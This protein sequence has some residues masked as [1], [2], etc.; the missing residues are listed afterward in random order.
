MHEMALHA[1]PVGQLQPPI[2]TDT[3]RDGLL[4]AEPLSAG[5][6]S[7]LS[8]C[9]TAIEGLLETFLAMDVATVRCL[10]VFNFVRVAYAMVM[11]I[12]LYFSAASPGS[13]LGRVIRK[14]DMRAGHYLDRLL[15]KFRATAADDRSR[16]AAKF[17]V[18]LVMLRSWFS[19]QARGSGSDA[20]PQQM[21][22]P[23]AT[24]TPGTAGEVRRGSSNDPP[25]QSQ[26]VNTPLQLLS[27]VATGRT[28]GSGSGPG[29]S[30]PSAGDTPTQLPSLSRWVDLRQPPQPFFHDT[31]HNNDPTPSSAA[32]GPLPH[33]PQTSMPPPPPSSSSSF[34]PNP[35]P[36]SG[37]SSGPPNNGIPMP[38]ADLLAAM[39]PGIPPP[40]P[41]V[42]VQASGYASDLDFG[43]N[44][45][46]D[47]ESMGFG[48]GSQNMYE[49]GVRM[50]LDEP[51]F[52]DI[53]EHMPGSGGVFQF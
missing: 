14:E 36:G 3:L 40:L 31:A 34:I 24:A 42:N 4:A 26:T 9:L 5:H 16:P 12:K 17:L 8:A 2:M 19:K 37:P 7:A 39:A 15:D 27:E 49:D 43:L 21:P 35:N 11:L 22:T 25:P 41:G 38:S 52:S 28:P 23:A 44:V 1:R 48:E 51:W 50:L 30:A 32:D 10:P 53:F 13:E 45:G 47:L 6:I 18:V 29:P 20:A 46:F 33:P